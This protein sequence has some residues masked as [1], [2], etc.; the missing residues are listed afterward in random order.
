LADSLKQGIHAATQG[1]D[2]DKL[3]PA[4]R[5]INA[6]THKTENKRFWRAVRDKKKFALSL[7]P[8]LERDSVDLFRLWLANNCDF[9]KLEARIKRKASRDTEGKKR[10]AWQKTRDSGY[11]EEQHKVLKK[12]PWRSR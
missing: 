10:Y 4:D 11:S 1:Q 8:R 9:H 12:I 7:G 2:E 6:N 5:D 3:R